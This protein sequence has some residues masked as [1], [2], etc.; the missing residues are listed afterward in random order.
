MKTREEL[1]EIIKANSS[2]N[3]TQEACD[4][5]AERIADALN[6]EQFLSKICPTCEGTGHVV[7]DD[8]VG[9][10]RPSKS[11]KEEAHECQYCRGSG[12]IKRDK[13][14]SS[15]RRSCNIS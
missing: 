3:M 1:I 15:G 12:Y 11:D 5:Q 8:K 10:F 7:G 13:R 14:K 2:Q 4:R 9:G 6:K